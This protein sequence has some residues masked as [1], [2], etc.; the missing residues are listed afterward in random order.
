L[1]PPVRRS[2][3]PQNGLA[4]LSIDITGKYLYAGVALTAVAGSPF[5]TGIGKAG[6]AAT[7][8]VQ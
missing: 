4:Q 5:S 6:V 8:V 7:N 3:L 2:L 1:A